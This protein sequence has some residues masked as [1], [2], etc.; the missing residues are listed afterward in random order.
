VA[1]AEREL[2]NALPL[3]DQEHLLLPGALHVR[4]RQ[5]CKATFQNCKAIL[6]RIVKPF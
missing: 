5:D 2:G 4:K 1:R 3:L 6:V